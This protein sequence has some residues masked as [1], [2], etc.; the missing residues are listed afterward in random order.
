MLKICS[1]SKKR[2]ILRGEGDHKGSA[3]NLNILAI[4][5]IYPKQLSVGIGGLGDIFFAKKTRGKISHKTLP[6]S[7][8]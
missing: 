7:F 6:L 3:F 5:N 8:A 4:L 1:S 2:L